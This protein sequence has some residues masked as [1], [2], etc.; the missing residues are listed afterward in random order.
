[1]RFRSAPSAS[2]V[3]LGLRH[4]SLG[5]ECRSLVPDAFGS[6]WTPCPIL[7]W[8]RTSEDV[9][10]RNCLGVGGS[11]SCWVLGLSEFLAPSSPAA[12]HML[13]PLLEF[14]LSTCQGGRAWAGCCVSLGI[15]SCFQTRGPSCSLCSRILQECWPVHQVG[16]ERNK[17][18]GGQGSPPCPDDG[19]DCHSVPHPT[20]GLTRR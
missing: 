16:E 5:S 10:N 3:P 9:Q 12:M 13:F 2:F 15:P 11:H 18:L 4:E 8:R 17:V 6:S 19:S 14:S 1:M 20:P 7:E